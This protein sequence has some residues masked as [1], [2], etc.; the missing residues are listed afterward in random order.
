VCGTAVG[1]QFEASTTTLIAGCGGAKTETN[2]FLG[3]R[4]S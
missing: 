1:M 3:L 2:L 4:V